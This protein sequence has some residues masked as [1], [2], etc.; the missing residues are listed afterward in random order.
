ME[1]QPIPEIPH[2][3]QLHDEELAV[4]ELTNDELTMRAGHAPRESLRPYLKKH[5]PT[6]IPSGDKNILNKKHGGLMLLHGSVMSLKHDITDLQLEHGA[7]VNIYEKGQTIAHRAAAANDALML[8]IIYRYGG[9]FSLINEDGETPLMIAITLGY[10][11]AI[12]EILNYWNIDTSSG[13]NETILHYAA[14][15]NNP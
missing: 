5:I 4:V 3:R 2:A 12:N 9:D 8:H 6:P 7:N 10:T 14:R 1:T 11:R 13:N 15:H